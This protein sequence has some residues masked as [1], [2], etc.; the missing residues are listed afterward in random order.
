MVDTYGDTYL[1]NSKLNSARIELPTDM[2]LGWYAYAIA[3]LQEAHIITGVGG[4]L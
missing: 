2:L 1:S 4:K 3:Y